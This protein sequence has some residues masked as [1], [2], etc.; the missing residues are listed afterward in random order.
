MDHSAE[1]HSPATARVWA[2]IGFAVIATAAVA[3]NSNAVTPAQAAPAAA[4]RAATTPPMAYELSA[5]VDWARTPAAAI[6]PGETVGAYD[7]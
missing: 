3:F 7:R 5:T 6:T 2:A 1:Q 4:A